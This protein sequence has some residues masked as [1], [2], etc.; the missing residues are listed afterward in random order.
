MDKQILDTNAV[1]ES[2]E[3]NAAEAANRP[4]ELTLIELLSVGGGEGN[5]SWG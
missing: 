3:D 4:I 1:I 5:T 2:N